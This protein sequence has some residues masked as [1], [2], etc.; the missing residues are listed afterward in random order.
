MGQYVKEALEQ[1]YIHP[2]TSLGSASVF[3]VKK[4]DG[5]LRPCVDYRGL[6]KMLIQYPHPLPLVPVVLDHSGTILQTLLRNFLYYKIGKICFVK[7]FRT[8]AQP[9]MDLLRGQ[10]KR[11]NWNPGAE[12][13]F[14]ELK[15]AFSSTPV[16][17]QP[18]LRKPFVVE[19]DTSNGT[20]RHSI[21]GTPIPRLSRQ[22]NSSANAVNKC[23]Q[24]RTSI[25]A[26]WLPLTSKKPIG[27][28]STGKLAVKYEG[29]CAIT[30]RV[31]D[32]TYKISLPGGS[33]ASRAFH[34][35]VLKLVVVG[36]LAEG[37]NFLGPPPPPPLEIG[38][39]LAY[40]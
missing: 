27:A 8:L 28:G 31:N 15:D 5:S 34:V 11:L 37:S 25:C 19:V 12:R 20:N 36:P 17:R 6:N 29:P 40:R 1:G 4:K 30:G 35:P 2:S 7:S 16:L 10:N 32:V 26:R 18:N 13:S 9:L 3:F 14:E 24:R 39:G 23:G 38:G 21:L 22:W 33:R